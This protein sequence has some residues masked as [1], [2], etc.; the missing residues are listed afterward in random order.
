MIKSFEFYQDLPKGD[1][2]KSSSLLNREVE[3][4]KQ[5]TCRSIKNDST[6]IC[7]CCNSTTVSNFFKKW[8]VNYLRCDLCGTIFSPLPSAEIER[9]HD[10]SAL[11]QLRKSLEYQNDIENKRKVQWKE[12]NDWIY[13]RSFRY[14]SKKTG[15]SIL[16]IGNR[17]KG[18]Q[19]II[20]SS[21]YCE[22][23]VCVDSLTSDNTLE[24]VEGLFD[25]VIIN[26][27]INH[28]KDVLNDLMPYISK[29]SPNGLLFIDLRGG[30]GFDILTIKEN[31]PIFPFEHVCLPT[32]DGLINVFNRLNMNILDFS[33]PGM[34]DFRYVIDHKECVPSNDY[35][36]K[37]L[38]DIE[39]PEV[40]ADFQYFLQKSGLSSYIRLVVKKA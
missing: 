14:I 20:S 24:S 38:V 13:L 37:Q 21:K 25:I 1:S 2:L 7:P 16:D 40:Q 27:K 15:Y 33:T 39:D 3:L 29:L 31:A 32:K 34:M 22:K 12:F 10:Y 4:I 26:E 28:S 35:F 19:S 17:Y 11:N 36:I 6:S 23:Y 30:A 9:Y 18:L 5:F 8:D